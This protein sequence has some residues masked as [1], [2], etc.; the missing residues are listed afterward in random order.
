MTVA[1][2]ELLPGVG[3]VGPGG[4]LTVATLAMLP[5]APGATV[6]WNVTVTAP[7]EGMVTEPLRLEP[8]LVKVVVLA[9]GLVWL[10]TLARPLRPAGKVSLK[11]A[12]VAVLGPALLMT[13]L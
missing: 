9:P 6:A 4:G 5:V 13:R 8:V 12:P 10:E 7:P 11:L 3:S 1:V 2:P